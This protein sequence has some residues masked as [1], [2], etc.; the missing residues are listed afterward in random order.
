M[1]K[2]MRGPR[3][4][5]AVRFAAVTQMLQ[6]MADEQLALHLASP[7]P[8]PSPSWQMQQGP[9]RPYVRRCRAPS[10]GRRSEFPHRRLARVSALL[11]VMRSNRASDR[12]L[13]SSRCADRGRSLSRYRARPTWR[14]RKWRAGSPDHGRPPWSEVGKREIKHPDSGTATTCS[15]SR[16]AAVGR[17]R[18]SAPTDHRI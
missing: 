2:R 11:S 5:R 8:A 12:A 17:T 13:K 14:P 18:S 15:A 7:D 10:R 1:V 9:S 16:R 3:P 6:S 4:G